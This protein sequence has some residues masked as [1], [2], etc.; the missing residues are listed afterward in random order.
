MSYGP[1]SRKKMDSERAKEQ[2][3]FKDAGQRHASSRCP[4]TKV[5]PGEISDA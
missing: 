2:H 3:R 1:A 5:K 4:Y